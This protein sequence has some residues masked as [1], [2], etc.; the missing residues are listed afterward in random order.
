MNPVSGDDAL[1]YIEVMR[2]V[3]HQNLIRVYD[4]TYNED[5]EQLE[6]IMEYCE[7]GDLL[8]YFA[9]NKKVL[10][11]SQILKIV[12]QIVKGFIALN[13]KGIMHRDLKPENVL[14]KK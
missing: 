3:I 14:I 2:S 1:K 13:V 8:H 6:I 5:T 7:G 11:T 10:Q 4:S 9:D 12:R